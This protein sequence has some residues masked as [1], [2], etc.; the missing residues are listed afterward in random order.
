MV[1]Y[2]YM[3]LRDAGHALLRSIIKRAARV[4]VTGIGFTVTTARHKILENYTDYGTKGEGGGRI[5]VAPL[6]REQIPVTKAT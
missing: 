5:T 3:D 1:C 2:A 6:I 4:T